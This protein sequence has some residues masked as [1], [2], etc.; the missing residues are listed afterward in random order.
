MSFAFHALV[1]GDAWSAWESNLSVRLQ[2][3]V[4]RAQAELVTWLKSRSRAGREITDI[5][6]VPETFGSRASPKCAL[7]GGQTNWMLEWLVSS[8]FPRCGDSMFGDDGRD[9]RGAGGNLL[10]LLEL[11]RLHPVSFPM[12]HVQEFHDNSFEFLKRYNRL[13]IVPKP[14]DHMLVHM[15]N[16][17][18]RQG[19]PT[20]YGCWLDESINRLLRDVAA[21]A[22]SL[23]HDRRVLSEFG[24]ALERDSA[25]RRRY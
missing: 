5:V 6:L 22:H 23:V 13:R 19:S 14:K 2:L 17:I 10:R 20:L 7:K 3:S 1:A 15:S 8:V 4:L 9:I 11:I 24:R 21:G 18:R 12:G 25:K 16:R